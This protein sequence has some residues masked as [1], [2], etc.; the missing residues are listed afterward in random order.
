M[1]I[2]KFV[3]KEFRFI[4][5]FI[6]CLSS[7]SAWRTSSYWAEVKQHKCSSLL[8]TLVAF[9]ICREDD[10][11]QTIH[12]KEELISREDPSNT[13]QCVMAGYYR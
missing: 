1:L 9:L 7:S 6:F 11:F 5:I 8:T 13:F 4:A 3:G 10:I 12:L 2:Y